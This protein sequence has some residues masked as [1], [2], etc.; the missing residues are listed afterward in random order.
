MKRTDKRQIIIVDD[1]PDFTFLVEKAFTLCTPCPT[2]KVLHSGADLLAWLETGQR[3]RLILLDINMPEATGFDILSILKTAGSYKFIPVIML[4]ISEDRQD[5]IRSYDNGA[6]AYICKPMSYR[7]LI[8]HMQLLSNY[9][10]DIST[11]PD[12]A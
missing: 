11:T 3:P 8:S 4:S 9:W 12:G 5:V 2:I 10:F 7:D 1:N 6:N